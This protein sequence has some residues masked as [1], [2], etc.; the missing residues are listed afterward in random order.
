MGRGRYASCAQTGRPFS[1]RMACTGHLRAQA[2]ADAAVL[3]AKV[4]RPAR[5]GEPLRDVF[6][7]AGRGKIQDHLAPL[8]V[9]VRVCAEHSTFLHARQRGAARVIR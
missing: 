2:A 7:A 3:H 1:M 5:G 8:R 9:V 6:A 4:R